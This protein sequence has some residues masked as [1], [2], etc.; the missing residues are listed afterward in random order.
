MEAQSFFCS[1]CL[2]LASTKWILSRC[3]LLFSLIDPRIGPWQ[4]RGHQGGT[5]VLMNSM[6]ITGVISISL[7]SRLLH[8][9]IGIDRF[10]DVKILTEWPQDPKSKFSHPILSEVLAKK[11]FNLKRSRLSE[12]LIE[13]LQLESK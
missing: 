3:L 12:S 10:M 13:N 5:I 6:S 9:F 7:E 2:P 8:L 1:S 4:D 11:T